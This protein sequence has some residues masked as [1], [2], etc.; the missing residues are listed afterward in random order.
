MRR[1]AVVLVAACGLSARLFAQVC[2]TPPVAQSPSN[3]NVVPNTAITYTWTAAS[4]SPTGYEVFVDGNVNSPA[5][6]TPSTTCQGPGVAAGKH[7]WI[8]RA[9]YSTCFADS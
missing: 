8:A 6:L 4:G 3:V 5:C 7:N 9:I 1:V 2:A